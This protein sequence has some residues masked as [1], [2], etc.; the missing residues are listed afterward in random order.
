MVLLA[1]Q[2]DGSVVFRGSVIDFYTTFGSQTNTR[3][4]TL[5]SLFLSLLS[6]GARMLD[7]QNECRMHY[8][9]K[10]APY[11]PFVEAQ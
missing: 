4:K 5:I 8:P 7:S 9:R 2:T 3:Q 11:A 6:F 1:I 10:I